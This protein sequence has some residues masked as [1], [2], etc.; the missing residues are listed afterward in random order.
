MHENF[1]HMQNIFPRFR[2]PHLVLSLP[3]TVLCWLLLPAAAIAQTSIAQ[4]TESLLKNYTRLEDYVRNADHI[5]DTEIQFTDDLA[6]ESVALCDAIMHDT[7]GEPRTVA[8]YF[9]ANFV[10]YTGYVR[11]IHG[12]TVDAMRIY[13]TILPE[14]EAFTPAFF[15]LRY[16]IDERNYIIKFEDFAP[17]QAVVYTSIAEDL[18]AQSKYEQAASYSRKVTENTYADNFQKMLA[19]DYLL[20]SLAKL[21][22]TKADDATVALVMMKAASNLTTAER[23]V[24]EDTKYQP[25]LVGYNYFKTIATD[26][27]NLPHKIESYREAAGY[28]ARAGYATEATEAY[29]IVVNSSPKDVYTLREI[30]DFAERNAAPSVGLK[31]ARLFENNLTPSQCDDWTT[32][33]TRYTKFGDTEAA[34]NAQVKADKCRKDRD[35]QT[36]RSNGGF[37]A[38]AG[39]YVIPLLT[40]YNRYRDYGGV[41]N[42]G[43]RRFTVELSYTKINKNRE[44]VTT[45]DYRGDA[46][47]VH[48]WNGYYTHL[49]LKFGNKSRRSS[50]AGPLFGYSERTLEPFSATVIEPSGQTTPQLFKPV[51][52]QYIFMLNYGTMGKGRV[53][54]G[55][56][57]LG[58]GLGYNTLD[59]G[60]DIWRRG[61]YTYNDKFLRERKERFVNFMMRCGFTVGLAAGK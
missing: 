56:L 42:L 32:L 40:T 54:G 58:L 36:H 12:K 30:M 23:K 10:R 27:P 46:L 7:V 4:K 18:I 13:S 48:Y 24:C 59:V 17:A 19:S 3:T 53:L 57:F 49:A 41:L 43:T 14:F 33:A 34:K 6:R 37:R 52:K 44:V 38:Y 28:L 1:L 31:A 16:Q 21:H 26:Y 61:G 29:E 60:N 55:D 39:V 25:E 50:Y 9:R 35:R 45:G 5:G 22:R 51:R 8:R 2:F 15:P 11:A 20:E 47:N